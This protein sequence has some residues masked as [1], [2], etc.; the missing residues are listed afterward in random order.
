MDMPLTKSIPLTCIQ[1]CSVVTSCTSSWC[2]ASVLRCGIIGYSQCLQFNTSAQ[3]KHVL[4]EG[5]AQC[6]K[7]E[8]GAQLSKAVS[9]LPEV[10]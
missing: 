7:V 5:G 6:L 3:V 9:K 1:E 10:H 4:H 2:V 8:G